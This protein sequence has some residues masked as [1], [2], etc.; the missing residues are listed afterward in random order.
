MPAHASKLVFV[1]AKQLYTV[2][3][4]CVQPYRHTVPKH[5]SRYSVCQHL[6]LARANIGFL[7]YFSREDIE[8]Q[9]TVFYNKSA[10]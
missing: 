3:V 10:I 4:R 9:P 7:L 8:S 5:V 2:N 1:C 6:K